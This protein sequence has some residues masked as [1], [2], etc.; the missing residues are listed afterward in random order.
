MRN[1]PKDPS[2]QGLRSDCENGGGEGGRLT[3]DSNFFSVTLY[4]FEKVGGAG[5]VQG[6]S[7]PSPSAD[8]GKIVVVL[9]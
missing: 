3:S 8:P 7:S 9:K 2:T 4:D 6:G 5:G 1:P